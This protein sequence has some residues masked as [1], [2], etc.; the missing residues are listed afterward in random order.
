M[1]SVSSLSHFISV[2]SLKI[3]L[4]N[5]HTSD[6]PTLYHTLLSTRLFSHLLRRL[7]PP[8][9]FRHIQR[10]Q[11]D[12]ISLIKLFLYLIIM[13][14]H[15]VTS[16]YTPVRQNS[17]HGTRSIFIASIGNPV[18]TYD[19][20][21]HNIGH[22]LFDQLVTIYWKDHLSPDGDYYK[23]SKY[24]NVVLYKSSQTF[25]NLQGKPIQK[26]FRKFTSDSQLVILHD[27]LQVDL[28]KFQL[29]KPGTS[30]RGH[31]GLKSI[32]LTIGNNYWKIG[33]G[34]GRP[35]SLGKAS[36]VL[37]FVMSKFDPK[38]LE[39]I[40]YE[41]FPKIVSSIEKLLNETQNEK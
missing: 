33:I 2:W 36:E 10:H 13:L 27:E 9:L 30:A 19:N 31:N 38:Q 7:L 41:V 29:R 22:R 14:K 15:L 26:H 8:L 39:I 11:H 20:T 37:D 34:I 35:N 23:S 17:A 18:P 16:L 25:M 28:G 6:T 32:N 40:D 24:P 1:T 21:R 12:K 3:K 5:V 4:Q